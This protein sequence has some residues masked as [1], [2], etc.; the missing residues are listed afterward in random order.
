MREVGRCDLPGLQPPRNLEQRHIV[1]EHTDVLVQRTCMQGTAYKRGMTSSLPPHFQAHRY[2]HVRDQ[3]AYYEGSPSPKRV[4]FWLMRLS[5]SSPRFC[6]SARASEDAPGLSTCASRD[7]RLPTRPK[8]CGAKPARS[9]RNAIRLPLDWPPVQE[10][11][12]SHYTD[13]IFSGPCCLTG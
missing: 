9:L 11:H 5:T 6:R 2:H 10:L 4:P 1:L 7:R 3:P 13:M 8:C 12:L